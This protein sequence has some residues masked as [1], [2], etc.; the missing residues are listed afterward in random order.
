[1]IGRREG[2]LGMTDFQTFIATWESCLLLSST[3]FRSSSG[4]CRPQT[5]GEER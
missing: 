2:A 1:M 4:E 5:K 3:P